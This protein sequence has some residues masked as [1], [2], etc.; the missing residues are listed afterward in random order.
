MSKFLSTVLISI[1]LLATTYGQCKDLLEHSTSLNAS[2]LSCVTTQSPYADRGNGHWILYEL[3]QMESIDEI[4]LWNFNHP[5]R[6]ADGIKQLLIDIS[7][8]GN[9]WVPLDTIDLQQASGANDYMGQV[10]SGLDG[11]FTA[12][13]IL[14]TALS[15]HGGSCAGLSEVRFNLSQTTVPTIENELEATINIFPNPFSE[16]VNIVLTEL[17]TDQLT[18]SLY[19]MSG[20]LI[21]K[22]SKEVT[23]GSHHYSIIGSHLAQGIYSLTISSDQGKTSRQLTITH[24]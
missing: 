18:F 22:E 6:L 12:K 1:S 8:D 9:T 11:A 10:V 4:R 23:G 14:F 3:E 5:D 2:W 7:L 13:Y 17:T 20:A 24:P 15:N 16:R 19:D 21:L